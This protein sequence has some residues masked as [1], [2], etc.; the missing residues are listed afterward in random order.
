MPDFLIPRFADA[1]LA[2]TGE[3]LATVS[4]QFTRP[5]KQNKRWHE[6]HVYRTD[7][8]KY[9]VSIL[10]RCDTSHDDPYDEAE[11]FGTPGD[12]VEYLQTF[13]P[14]DRVRGWPVETHAEQDRRLREALTANFDRLVAQLIGS[15][16]EF[17][18]RV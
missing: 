10:F 6:I 16:A 7:S 11:V 5:G 15:R 2:F 3:R 9:V 1:P 8:G 13:D 17:A 14:V 18:E 4:G 12:V